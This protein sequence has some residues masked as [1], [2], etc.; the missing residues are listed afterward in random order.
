MKNEPKVNL[1]E[2]LK[3]VVDAKNMDDSVV[4]NALKQALVSAAKKY[5]HVDKKIDVEI[6]EDEVHVFLRAKVVDDYPD[7]DPSMTAEEVQKMDE[8][9]MLV[10]EAQEFDEE[11]QPGDLLEMEVPT[12]TFGRQ[13]IQTAKQLLTQQIRDAE[14]QKILDTYKGRIGSMISGEVLRLEGRNVIVSLGKQTEAVIPPREQIS[15]ERLV[16]GQSVKAVI[17]RVEESS[18]N[19]AQVVLSRANGDFLKEL[20]RQEVP[21]IYEGSVEI[22]GVAREPGYRAKIAVY[23][24]DEKID[25]VGACVGM[26]GARVQTIVREL[27]NERIDIVHWSADQDVFITRA[28]APA[29]IVKLSEVP[30]TQRVVVVINDENLAQA[31]GKNGQNVKLAATLVGRDLDVFGEKE[32]SEKDEAAKAEVLKP[33]EPELRRTAHKAESLFANAQPEE[34]SAEAAAETTGE[35]A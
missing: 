7:Y 16:Q 13:A 8:E 23:S 3:A 4:L 19:G 31:I 27:G 2:A 20:F 25:P 34:D 32:W 29:N 5:L 12:T 21:E 18:K 33:R 30:G 26:K 24:R 9:Y 6:D 10:P 11:A 15:H 28:L 17:A 14:R 1:L 22:K 35:E